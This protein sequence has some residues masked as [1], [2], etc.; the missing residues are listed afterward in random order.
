MMKTV[1]QILVVSVVSLGLSAI[2]F[3]RTG[4]EIQEERERLLADAE[5]MARVN[6]L[7]D[8][9]S[10]DPYI[11]CNPFEDLQG[12]RGSVD[13][14]FYDYGT[15]RYPPPMRWVMGNPRNRRYAI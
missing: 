15:S 7:L 1:L 10:E 4:F 12:G 14:S 6:R 11:A 5:F 9:A 13:L 8:I 2:V 3:G